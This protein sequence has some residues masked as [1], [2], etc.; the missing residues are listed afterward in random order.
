MRWLGSITDEAMLAPWFLSS[1]LL[2]HPSGIGLTLLHAFGYGLPVVTNDDAESQMPE[3]AAF[4]PGETGVQFRR[5]ERHSPAKAVCQCL[6]EDE[7]RASMARKAKR[8]AR[9]QYNIMIMAKRFTGMAVCF[10]RRPT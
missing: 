3:F 7:K 8:V 9:E 1:Q 4:T 2:V 10:G 5:G 6:T